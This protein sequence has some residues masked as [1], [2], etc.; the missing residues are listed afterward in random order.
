MPTRT[1][2]ARITLDTVLRPIAATC[3]KCGGRLTIYPS[4]SVCLDGC[5]PSFS[6]KMH[7]GMLDR[8]RV[9]AGLSPVA[10]LVP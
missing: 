6:A 5:S 2:R 1:A 7:A 9:A 10:E 4:G 8:Q 3:G